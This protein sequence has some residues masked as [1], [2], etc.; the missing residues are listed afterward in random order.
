MPTRHV[1]QA[2]GGVEARAGDEAQVVRRRPAR[3]ASGH[4]EQRG[5]PRLRAPGA[6]AGEPLR[7]QR[8][9]DAIEAHD[10]G[11]RA[12]RDQVQQRGEIRL[13][14]VGERAALRAASRGWPSS[15]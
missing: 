14:P 10:V 15:T 11:D 1:G 7:D 5:D 8:A 3:V 9:V 4:G 2:P 13:R 12:Q 6:D